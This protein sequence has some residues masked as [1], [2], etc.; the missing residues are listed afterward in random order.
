MRKHR[1]CYVGALGLAIGVAVPAT[2]MASGIQNNDAAF[3]PQ[4]RREP[5]L[6]APTANLAKFGR[7]GRSASACSL[8]TSWDRPQPFRRSTSMRRRS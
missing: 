2:A 7:S 3:S 6:A 4:K 8:R 1:F 5:D